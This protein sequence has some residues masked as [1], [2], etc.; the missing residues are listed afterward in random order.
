M[1][2]AL[3]EPDIP[4]NA[5]AMLRLGACLDVGV[6]I[7]GQP[8]FVLSD[9]RLR[10]AGLDYIRLADI[11]RFADL[12]ALRAS[13]APPGR[14]ILLTTKG[15]TDFRAV[16]YGESDVLLLGR[17]S[18]GVPADVHAGADL[19]VTIPLARG[20][21][22]LNVAT[23]AAMVLSEALRQTRGFPGDDAPDPSP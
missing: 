3:F 10:R 16:A 8:G 6:A 19:R 13:I 18:A 4:Q 20:A 1:Q 17:E 7:V 22:S 21:R 5:G 23:A 14:L 12:A 2:I 9:A 15:D 11:R